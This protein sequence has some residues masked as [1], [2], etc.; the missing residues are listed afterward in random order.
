MTAD[1]IIAEMVKDL[2]PQ[3]EEMMKSAAMECCSWCDLEVPFQIVGVYKD[4]TLTRHAGGIT[5]APG[6]WKLFSGGPNIDG[7]EGVIRDYTGWARVRINYVDPVRQEKNT[8]Y[9]S[10]TA[11]DGV[12]VTTRNNDRRALLC[13]ACIETT[14]LLSA[15]YYENLNDGMKATRVDPAQEEE[16][17]D[18]DKCKHGAFIVAECPACA[19]DP[20]AGTCE[21]SHR[22]MMICK[23]CG[24]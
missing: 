2:K 5:Q 3:L 17:K 20:R 23:Y 7:P 4:G 13:P 18:E 11:K 14:G 10:T 1:E 12:S 9:Q 22:P 16:K 6:K 19:V 21:S 24:L 15:K 8:H